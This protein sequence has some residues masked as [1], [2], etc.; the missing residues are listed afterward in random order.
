MTQLHDTSEAIK[1]KH[2]TKDERAQ[3]AILKKEKYCNST[4]A[5]RL[6][7]AL[8]TINNEINRGTVQQMKRQ[9]LKGKMYDAYL[10]MTAI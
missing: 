10:R 6:V 1:E 5:D 7:R 4:I 3:I 8:Q 2:L 9:T